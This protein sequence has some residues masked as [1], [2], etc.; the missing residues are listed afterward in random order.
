MNTSAKWNGY[1]FL[2]E[3]SAAIKLLPDGE[4]HADGYRA[5]AV[6]TDAYRRLNA[7]EQI[8]EIW[9]DEEGE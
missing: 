4:L 5:S 2:V 8:V 1:M 6:D 7:D 3:M 9:V